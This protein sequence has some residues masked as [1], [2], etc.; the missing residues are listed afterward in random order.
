MLFQTT[1]VLKQRTGLWAFV[2]Q[3]EAADEEHFADVAEEPCSERGG[4]SG[5]L[6]AACNEPSCAVVGQ[7]GYLI[8]GR[9]PLYCKAET[10]CLWELARLESHYHPSVQAF[11]KKVAQVSVFAS[12]LFN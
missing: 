2:L 6:I 8:G 11:A 1:Q 5:H 12:Y 10:S 4:G 9:N 7:S 3:S